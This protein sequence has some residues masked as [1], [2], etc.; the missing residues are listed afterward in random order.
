M[1]SNSDEGILTPDMR[2]GHQMCI[3]PD[4]GQIFLYGGWN[5]SKELGDLWQ[6]SITSNKW[7]CLSLDTSQQVGSVTGYLTFSVRL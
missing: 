2:G 1:L 5:G 7:T 6:F 4:E 3:D